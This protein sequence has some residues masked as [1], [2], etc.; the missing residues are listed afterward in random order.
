MNLG[1]EI[2][3]RSRAAVKGGWLI[4]ERRSK[5]KLVF[6]TIEVGWVWGSGQLAELVVGIAS[7]Q[8]LA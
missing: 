4:W 1:C 8:T 3:A 2:S 6:N 7:L 5:Y